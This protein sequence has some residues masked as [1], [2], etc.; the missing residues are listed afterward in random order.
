MDKSSH[1]EVAACFSSDEFRFAAAHKRF[2]HEGCSTLVAAVVFHHSIEAG[3][4]FAKQAVEITGIPVVLGI[5]PC[6]VM[7]KFRK[8]ARELEADFSYARIKV[9]W[10]VW[11]RAAGSL[12]VIAIDNGL[13]MVL[14]AVTREGVRVINAGDKSASRLAVGFPD[15]SHLIVATPNCVYE[16]GVRV[17][18]AVNHGS[19]VAAGAS[20]LLLVLS[21]NSGRKIA[22]VLF[23]VRSVIVSPLG[24]AK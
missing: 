18:D 17:C 3:L 24:E 16:P 19:D 20:Q 14:T 13:G 15:C 11:K 1:D 21:G 2:A 23:D 7:T 8:L 12:C 5:N 9:A 6:E 10:V 22:G 4:G